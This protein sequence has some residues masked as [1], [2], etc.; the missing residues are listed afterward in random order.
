MDLYV[1]FVFNKAVE[2]QFKTFQRGFMKMCWGRLLQIFRPEELTAMVVGNEHDRIPIQ[3]MKAIKIRMQP[4]TDDR[5][6]PVVHTYFN[7][8]D[9]LCYYKAKERLQAIQQTQGFYSCLIVNIK[10]IILL[11]RSIMMLHK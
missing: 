9:L 5:C 8:L 11:I 10:G 2:S 4:I 1:D 3:G 7:L 6:L